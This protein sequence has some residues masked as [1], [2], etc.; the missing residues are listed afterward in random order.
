MI[1]FLQ[2]Q[3]QTNGKGYCRGLAGLVIFIALPLTEKIYDW[4]EPK[5]GR[6]SL[7]PEKED[8]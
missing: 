6:E 3:A 2:I 7:V 1:G 4:L 5:I 8:D